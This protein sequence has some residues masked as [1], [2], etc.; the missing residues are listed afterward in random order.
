DTIGIKHHAVEDDVAAATDRHYH[1]AEFEGSFMTDDTLMDQDSQM[2][3]KSYSFRIFYGERDPLVNILDSAVYYLPIE[4]IKNGKISGTGH[5]IYGEVFEN[6]NIVQGRVG[7]GLSL[8]GINQY[9]KLNSPTVNLRE[10]CFGD[11]DR[12]NNGAT[13]S[14]W[15]KLGQKDSSNMYYF[16]SGG[17][18]K[19]SHGI[20]VLWKDGSLLAWMSSTTKLWKTSWDWPE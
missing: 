1:V 18:T 16:S 15:I 12:C 7:G 10:T 2:K 11:L 17:Q 20:A 8:D 13:L 4:E 6:P 9:V 3:N 5:G 14:L 19:Y